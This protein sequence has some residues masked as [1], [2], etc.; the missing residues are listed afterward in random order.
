GVTAN[1][2]Q[3]RPGVG[4]DPAFQLN[5]DGQQITQKIASSS[6]GQPRLSREAV[7]EF[8][9]VTNL[10]DVTQGRSLG[11]QV[12]AVSRAGTNSHSGTLYG[13]FRSDELTAA[14][15]GAHRG[16]PVSNPQ[17][18]SPLGGP[19]VRD[20]LQYF[21]AYEYERSPYTLFLV[22]SG[23]SGQSFALPTKDTHHSAF[24]RVDF[25]PSVTTHVVVRGQY[26]HWVN[27]FADP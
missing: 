20:R 5:L 27:P 2:V 24:G 3:S 25:E 15:A 26:W 11:E 13:Y 19:I 16:L 6:F 8:Q 7:A 14:D 17:I 23:F 12:Q 9:I 10:F 18:G 22:P 4:R 21:G 1:F